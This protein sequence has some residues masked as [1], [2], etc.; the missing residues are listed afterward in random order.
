MQPIWIYL[1]Y[2][3]NS[4][5]MMFVKSL[6]WMFVIVTVIAAIV[7]IWQLIDQKEYGTIPKILLLTLAILALPFVVIAMIALSAGK[8]Q[9]RR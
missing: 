1:T 8:Q 4:D 6:F 3:N 9:G 2:Q 5:G 7:R